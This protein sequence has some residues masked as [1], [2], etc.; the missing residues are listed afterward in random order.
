MTKALLCFF[1]FFFGRIRGFVICWA[2]RGLG[3]VTIFLLGFFFF[4][5]GLKVEHIILFI[6]LFEGVPNSVTKDVPNTEQI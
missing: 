5:F 6:Y 2:C 1:F 4:F 3:Y